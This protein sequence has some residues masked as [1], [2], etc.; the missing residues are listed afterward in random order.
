MFDN[1]GCTSKSECRT[2]FAHLVGRCREDGQ[3]FSQLKKIGYSALGEN[4]R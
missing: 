1:Q 3:P 2:K 4:A